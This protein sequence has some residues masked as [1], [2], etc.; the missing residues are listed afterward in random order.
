ML[1]VQGNLW[2]EYIATPGHAEDKAKTHRIAFQID[3]NDPALMN[4]VLNAIQASTAGG[5]IHI[6]VRKG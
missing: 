4:L 6:P 3:Q 1:G 2:T 5:E